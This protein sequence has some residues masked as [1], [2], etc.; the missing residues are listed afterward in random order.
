MLLFFSN[1]II[2]T[3]ECHHRGRGRHQMRV[4]LQHARTAST[5]ASISLTSITSRAMI[6][7]RLGVQIQTL[8]SHIG[9]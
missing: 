9:L 2:A 5:K 3:S 8:T 6:V 1:R 7:G 4:T